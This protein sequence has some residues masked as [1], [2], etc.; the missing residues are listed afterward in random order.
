MF[1]WLRRFF[2]RP[3]RPQYGITRMSVPKIAN[4]AE[5][6]QYVTAVVHSYCGLPINAID[7]QTPIGA[8]AMELGTIFAFLI[9]QTITLTTQ[10]TIGELLNM[11]GHHFPSES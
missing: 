10:T 8:A 4:R 9:T 1:H 3:S 5:L 2:N 7:D 6:R 11:V